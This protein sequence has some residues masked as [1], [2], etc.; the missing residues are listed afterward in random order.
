MKKLL[1]LFL[2][3]TIF[4][5]CDNSKSEIELLIES[6]AQKALLADAGTAEYLKLNTEMQAMIQNQAN[7]IEGDDVKTLKD[8][9]PN[10]LGDWSK[11]SFVFVDYSKIDAQLAPAGKSVM[12]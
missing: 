12:L 1:I 7:V 10:Q 2:M 8:V 4:I 3:T 11:R 6:M 5:G 9:H